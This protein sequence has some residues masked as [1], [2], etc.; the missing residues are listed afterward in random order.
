DVRTLNTTTGAF[1]TDPRG[2]TGIQD[3]PGIEES[4]TNT[5]EIGYKGLIGNRLLLS[6]N[7]WYENRTNFV[8]P[9]RVETPN[10]FLNGPQ[11]AQYLVPFLVG[12]GIPEAQATAIAQSVAIGTEAQP[13][14]ARI[15]LG[16]LPTVETTGDGANLMLTYRNFGDVDLFGGEVAARVLV[17]DE[18]YFDAN[19]A[20]VSDDEFEQDDGPA[21]ALNAPT[22][23]LN[24]ALGYR[25]DATG[26]NGKIQ[27]RFVN[28]FPV[29]SGVFIGEVDEYHLVDLTLGYRLPGLRG[30][31]LQVD[32]NNIF[33]D[34][35]TP[36]VGSP[37]IGRL[38][39][40]RLVY[41]FD[42]F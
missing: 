21:I 16:A 26:L 12:A 34:E 36:F 17:S 15:P 32:V 1:E 7:G 13:G 30:L 18:W 2:L 8:G 41:S 11:A 9:L 42:R 6:A 39:M 23:K 10:V 31:S 40:A 35:Y 24:G 22:V 27:Y 37:Q 20:L 33:D 25:S 4:I 19:L 29:N 38:A 3:I 14:M 28:G 5:F